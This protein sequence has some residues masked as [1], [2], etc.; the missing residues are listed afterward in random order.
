MLTLSSERPSNLMLARATTLN[1]SLISNA[2]TSS[3][4]TPAFLSALGIA[5]EGEVVNL[6]GSWAAS[7]Q[8]RILAIGFRLSSFS[9]ASETRTTAAAP[10]FSGDEFG[11]VTVPVPGMKAGLTVR[12][13][14]GL[15][16][17]RIRLVMSLI[18]RTF[19]KP[20]EMASVLH[21]S[22]L[23]LVKLSHRVFL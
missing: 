16:C 3:R 18:N 13:F 21:S 15:S 4:D 11:A 14:S 1:A 6:L 20:G 10:S 8:L 12:S 7:A 19:H 17:Q 2:S 9:F 23:H 5:R 22:V